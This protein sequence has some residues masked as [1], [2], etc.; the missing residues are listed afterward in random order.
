MEMVILDPR[1]LVGPPYKTLK[2]G[3]SSQNDT[4]PEFSHRHSNSVLA[5]YFFSSHSISKY[6]SLSHWAT[7]EPDL[8]L[9]CPTQ[10]FTSQNS[11]DNC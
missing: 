8:K 2:S 7:T 10:L 4:I 6:T 11:L 5:N 3:I 1:K 9:S